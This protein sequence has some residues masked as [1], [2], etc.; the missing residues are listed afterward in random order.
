MLSRVF[1]LPLTVWETAALGNI[2]FSVAVAVPY[3]VQTVDEKANDQR[4]SNWNARE[5]F[6]TISQMGKTVPALYSK[7]LVKRVCYFHLSA[8]PQGVSLWVNF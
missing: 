8:L 1:R 2:H 7:V 6:R 4:T 5:S 3:R